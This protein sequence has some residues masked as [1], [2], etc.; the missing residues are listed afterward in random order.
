MSERIG[1]KILLFLA[2]TVLVSGSASHAQFN[3]RAVQTPYPARGDIT[4]ADSPRTGGPLSD[5]MARAQAQA[6]TDDAFGKLRDVILHE[7][8]TLDLTVADLVVATHSSDQLTRLIK[9]AQIVG[10]Q[11]WLDGG[12]CQIQLQLSG[13][14][15]SAALERMASEN[16]ADSPIRAVEIHRN[17]A[18]WHRR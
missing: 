14:E 17:I 18:D 12:T 2:A 5:Q 9:N 10:G 3:E 11:R 8:L 1:G 13:A 15:V 16:A 6:A 7:N 4:H